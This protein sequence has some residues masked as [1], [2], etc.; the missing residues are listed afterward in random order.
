MISSEF[1]YSKEPNINLHGKSLYKQLNKNKTTYKLIKNSGHFDFLPLCK[2]EARKILK[3]EGEG[4]DIICMDSK[5]SRIE[6][7]EE[8]VSSILKFLQNINIIKK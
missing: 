5:K 2:K 3:M 1:Y 7:H 6:I 4:E 8:T